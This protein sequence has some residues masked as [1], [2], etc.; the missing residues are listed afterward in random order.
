MGPAGGPRCAAA[1]GP[2]AGP[3]VERDADPGQHHLEGDP[4]DGQPGRDEDLLEDRH[5][6]RGA[7]AGGRRRSRAAPSGDT[8]SV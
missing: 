6:H 8:A 1:A 5:R 2:A 3:G 7:L 4:A